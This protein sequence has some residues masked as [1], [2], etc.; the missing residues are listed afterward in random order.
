MKYNVIKAFAVAT[1]MTMVTA[2]GGNVSEDENIATTEVTTEAI[3]AEESE[4]TTEAITDTTT[5]ATETTTVT[6]TTEATT[7]APVPTPAPAPGSLGVVYNNTNIMLNTNIA[8]VT[9]VLGSTTDYSEA[10]SCNYDGLDKVFTYGGVSI[11]T[12]PHSSGDLINEIEVSDPAVI[13]AESVAP[14]GKSIEDI[15]ATYG[16]PTATEGSTY[17]YSKGNCYTYFYA[18]GGVVSYWG[19]VYEG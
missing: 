9:S 2:C 12:Y 5:V 6:T 7:S 16:E 11:Y 17:K 10:P 13:T 4:E 19:V 18:D 8:N 15:I 14:I 1:L 3:T